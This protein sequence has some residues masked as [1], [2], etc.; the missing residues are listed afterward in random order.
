MVFHETLTETLVEP[1]IEIIT[2]LPWVVPVL[3]AIGLAFLSAYLTLRGNIRQRAWLVVYQEKRQEIRSFLQ[4]LDEF[5]STVLMAGEVTDAGDQ[6]LLAQRTGLVF[7][8]RKIWGP[9]LARAQDPVGREFMSVLPT[10]EQ[11]IAGSAGAISNLRSARQIFLNAVDEKLQNL[12]LRSGKLRTTLALSLQDPDVTQRADRKVTAV[13]E[14]IHSTTPA[15]QN[16]DFGRFPGEWS[17]DI[18]PVKLALRRDLNKSSR[19]LGAAL[20]LSW[21]W[22]FRHS[23]MMKWR[24]RR[25]NRGG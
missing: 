16:L 21:R 12:H 5:A 4:T 9:D 22:R 10:P 11:V 24:H 2:Q 1:V 17:R 6:N 25:K 14:E 3:L 7:G 8:G 13:Y 20:R 23:R 19:S 18:S 15:Y